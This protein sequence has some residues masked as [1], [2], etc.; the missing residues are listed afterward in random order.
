M[1]LNTFTFRDPSGAGPAVWWDIGTL[2]AYYEVSMDLVSV[3]PTFSLYDRKWP[4]RSLP[5]NLPPAKTVFA[6]D[7]DTEVLRVGQALDSLVSGGCIISG[8]RVERSILGPL[9]RINSYAQVSDSILM[10]G[11]TVGRSARI[12]KAIIDKGVSI[13]AGIT[14]G[15]DLE[16]DARH[17]R[18]SPGGVVV[19]PKGEVIEAPA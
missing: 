3:S 1:P 4:I 10:D 19:V 17:F 18:I 14:L 5:R 11:V 16:H 9:V 12:R 13:P 6:Q 8:G 15:Y 7:N 2:D